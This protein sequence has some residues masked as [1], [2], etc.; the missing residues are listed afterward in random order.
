MD[1]SSAPAGI[2]PNELY[3]G[4]DPN[5]AQF[6]RAPNFAPVITEEDRDARKRKDYVAM[7]AAT[8]DVLAARLLALIAVVG[9]VLMFGWAVYDPQPWRV[10]ASVSYAVVVLWPLVYLHLRKG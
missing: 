9:A 5:V 7:L 1:R 4:P 3:E 2:D 8:V 6:P 10:Y